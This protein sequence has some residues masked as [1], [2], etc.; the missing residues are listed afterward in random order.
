[1]IARKDFTQQIITKCLN[2]R[3]SC[4]NLR[5]DP[6]PRVLTV[7]FP[8]LLPPPRLVSSRHRRM[9]AL[10]GFVCRLVIPARACSVV[11]DRSNG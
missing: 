7:I 2:R 11:E 5:Y 9:L 4:Q 8:E 1:M 10:S 6:F 3:V